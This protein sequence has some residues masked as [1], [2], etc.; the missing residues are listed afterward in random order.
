[1]MSKTMQEE[2]QA[3]KAVACKGPKKGKKLMQMKIAGRFEA[4][5]CVYLSS[6]NTKFRG[7]GT[8]KLM[9]KYVGPCKIE[10][11]VG[12]VAYRLVMPAKSRIHP[13]LRKPYKGSIAE[14]NEQAAPPAPVMIGHDKLFIFEKLLDHQDRKT[15]GR[16]STL[17]RLFL[18]RW[19]GYPHSED[20]HNYR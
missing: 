1:M 17:E 13:T 7:K 8:Q 6:K 11:K 15:P 5:Q 2:L 10:K 9:P 19:K 16:N 12:P 18:V 14:L 4:G 3:A 20:I